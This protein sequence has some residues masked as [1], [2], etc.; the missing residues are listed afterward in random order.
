MDGQ[1]DLQVLFELTRVKEVENN[2]LGT[3]H[4]RRRQIFTIGGQVF[5]AF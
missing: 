3:I 1:Y 4:L 2:I 5:F